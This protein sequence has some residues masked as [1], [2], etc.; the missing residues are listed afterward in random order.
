MP[1]SSEDQISMAISHLNVLMKQSIVHWVCT[2]DIQR[3]FFPTVANN[4][5][6]LREAHRFNSRKS[7]ASVISSIDVIL[8]IEQTTTFY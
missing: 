2:E 3:R 7:E 4:P 1:E 8:S 5:R 6:L